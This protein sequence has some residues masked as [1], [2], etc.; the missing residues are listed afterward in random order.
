MSSKNLGKDSPKGAGDMEARVYER[1]KKN[2]P[3]LTGIRLKLPSG[4]EAVKFFAL[5]KDNTH[6]NSVQLSGIGL[7]D[8]SCM[9]R[10]LV[11]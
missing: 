9:F 1:M 3:S 4:T 10:L 8:K 11:F 5:L 7:C 6:I 2:D